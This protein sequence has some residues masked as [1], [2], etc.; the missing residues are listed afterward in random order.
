MKTPTFLAP[1]SALF[2]LA[3]ACL[4][5]GIAQAGEACALAAP[6]GHGAASVTVR[7]SDLNLSTREGASALY[8]RISHAAHQV[9]DS[10]DIRDLTGRAVSARCEREAVTQAVR[11]VHSEQ[12]AA[13]VGVTLP[14]S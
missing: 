8:A 7:Y 14:Q 10:G 9:C 3:G 1:R 12:L 4:V 2:A 11:T 5:A 13:L 6:S